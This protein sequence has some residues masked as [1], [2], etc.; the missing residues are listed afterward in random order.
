VGN[1]PKPAAIQ[2]Y[3]TAIGPDYYTFSAEDIL[4]IVLDSSLIGSPEA[5]QDAARRQEVWLEKTLE[6][7]KS[8][9]NQQVLVFQHIPYFIHD[10]DEEQD[11]YNIPPVARR[12]YLDLLEKAGVKHVFSGHYHRNIAGKD[13]P[14]TQ[15]VTGAVGMPLGQSISGFEIVTVNGKDL[16]PVWLCLGGIPNQVDPLNPVATHCPQ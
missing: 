13:G 7:A 10:P 11:Y 16:S 4:G 9:P 5:A 3:R 12:K 1:T 2:A 8:T 14:L 15:I 6:T